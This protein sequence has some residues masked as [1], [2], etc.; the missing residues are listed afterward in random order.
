TTVPGLAIIT[1]TMVDRL[2][3]A[4]LWEGEGR[5]SS[6]VDIARCN[7]RQRVMQDRNTMLNRTISLLQTTTLN[8][9]ALSLMI[10]DCLTL[11]IKSQWCC[12]HRKLGMV[13]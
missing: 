8:K 9:L 13:A 4:H 5:C 7:Q 12:S 11:H 10:Q 3:V 1:G 2:Q 6:K